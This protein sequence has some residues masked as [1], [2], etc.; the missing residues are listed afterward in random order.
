MPDLA[1]APDETIWSRVPDEPDEILR[2]RD[3]RVAEAPEDHRD[4]IGEGATLAGM[5][6]AAAPSATFVLA[7]TAHDAR[8]LGALT[9]FA[10]A[11]VPPASNEEQAIELARSATLSDWDSFALAGE[12]G[13]ARGWRVTTPVAPEGEKSAEASAFWTTY[14]LDLEGVC[15]VAFLTPMFPE[16]AAVAQLHVER[17]LNTLEVA[18]S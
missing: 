14:A 13:S 7:L 4:R 11:D 8:V 3:A 12:F 10:Y 17:L 16:A 18:S 5:A 1:I 2:W 15:I 9:V 6:R